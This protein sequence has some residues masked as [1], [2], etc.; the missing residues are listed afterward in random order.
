MHSSE[1][2]DIWK[3]QA[4]EFVGPSF[5]LQNVQSQYLKER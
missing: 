1:A 4:E 5:G 3:P 2:V